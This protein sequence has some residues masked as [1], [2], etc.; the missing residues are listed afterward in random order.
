MTVELVKLAQEHGAT[1]KDLGSVWIEFDAGELAEFVAAILKQER[2]A[3][4]NIAVSWSDKSFE[5]EQIAAEIR[6]RAAAAMA[7]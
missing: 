5:A 2:E 7:G 1:V 3:C 6:A 4:A